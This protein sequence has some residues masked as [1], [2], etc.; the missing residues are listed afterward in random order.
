MRCVNWEGPAGRLLKRQSLV[1]NFR[2]SYILIEF[3]DERLADL[4]LL[5]IKLFRQRIQIWQGFNE[6]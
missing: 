5:S 1:I 3:G 6:I 2:V 4:S